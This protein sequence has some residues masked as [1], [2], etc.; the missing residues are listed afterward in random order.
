MNVIFVGH[1]VKYD[2]ACYQGVVLL[3]QFYPAVY[4]LFGCISF[5]NKI[6][7]WFMM[8][9]WFIMHIQQWSI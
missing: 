2:G 7:L 5:S 4:Q 6:V 3:Q 9:V 1:A 8:H